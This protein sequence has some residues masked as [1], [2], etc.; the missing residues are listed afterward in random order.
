NTPHNPTGKV[1]TRAE[2]ELIAELAREHDAV[3]IT[4][5]VYEHLVYDAATPPI[6]LVSLP[7]MDERGLTISSAA[8]TFSVTGWKIG[9]VHGP[10]ELVA[11]VR[12]VKQ[13][14]TFV[15]GAPF[16]PAVAHALRLPQA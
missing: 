5:E 10:A 6:P 14:L 9:W 7:G 16:Q 4:D 3:V 8:Q 2:L 11:A 12:A 15:G 13:Y 1:F